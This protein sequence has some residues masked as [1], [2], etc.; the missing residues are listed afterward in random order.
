ML[1]ISLNIHD[2]GLN[3][4]DPTDEFGLAIPTLDWSLTKGSAACSSIVIDA[5]EDVTSS[6]KKLECLCSSWGTLTNPS[7]RT[8]KIRGNFPQSFENWWSHLTYLV[9]NT[10]MT[11]HKQCW[12]SNNCLNVFAG[13]L[14]WTTFIQPMSLVWQWIT[15]QFNCRRFQHLTEVCQVCHC[16]PLPVEMSFCSSWGVFRQYFKV[17]SSGL[18]SL[19]MLWPS[20]RK[21]IAS[22]GVCFCFDFRRGSLISESFIVKMPWTF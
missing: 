5:K 4:V 15:R 7:W 1:L 6:V 8:R 18:D 10:S 13:N 3:N 21:S 12:I 14:A 9:I 20:H 17:D 2:H 11:K 22:I 19:I 16:F